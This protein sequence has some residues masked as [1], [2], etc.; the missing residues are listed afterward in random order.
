VGAWLELIERDLSVAI[1][2][3]TRDLGPVAD[4]RHDQTP[5]RDRALR[6][7]GRLQ[8]RFRTNR[9]RR[10]G[11][12]RKNRN[13]A[14]YEPEDEKGRQL[15]GRAAARRDLHE[16]VSYCCPRVAA[17]AIVCAP[18]HC[19]ARLTCQNRRAKVEIG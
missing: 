1:S 2:R 17:A 19:C 7:Y 9:L 18:H 10:L 3:A 4:N 13:G 12:L 14:G 8:H 15:D 16:N 6:G 5:K 11:A